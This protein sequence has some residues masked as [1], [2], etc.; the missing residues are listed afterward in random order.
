[1]IS[2]LDVPLA[3]RL[4][5]RTTA[6]TGSTNDDVKELAASGG[7]EGTVVIAGAQTAGKG[8]LGRSFYS[9]EN[10][11]LYMSVLLRPTL[12]AQD[13]LAITTAAAVATAGAIDALCGTDAGIK[14][15]NDIYLG[16]RK[17]CGILTESSVSVGGMINYAVLGIGVNVAAADY[18]AEIAGKAGALGIAP[19]LRMRLAAGILMRFFEIYDRLPSRE[20][21]D[22][23]RRRSIL[24]GQMI[25][26]E[27]DGI[28]HTGIVAGIDDDARL[29]IKDEDGVTLS[30]S[31]G[32]VSVKL[33]K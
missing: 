29:L 33:G 30:L 6:V 24:T 10:V 15:V 28:A 4:D 3:G 25:E 20:Y 31:S 27:R 2:E 18:P 5:I 14:W 32:E 21:M 8:R 1:M 7:P 12:A 23:Y 9:P 22:E 13:A 17:V 16:D 19:E 11:G 26:Y